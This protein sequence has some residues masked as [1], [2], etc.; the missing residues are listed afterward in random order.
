MLGRVIAASVYNR[1]RD[2]L[3]VPVV[4]GTVGA[5]DTF[6]VRFFLSTVAFGQGRTTDVYLGRFTTEQPTRYI[7]IYNKDFFVF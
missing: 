4:I 5:S 3:S 6:S 1:I 7:Y 2:Y